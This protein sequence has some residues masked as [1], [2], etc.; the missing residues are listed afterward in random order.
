MKTI[1]LSLFFA[2]NALSVIRA[3]GED[4]VNHHHAAIYAH[5]FGCE[6][7]VREDLA[8]DNTSLQKL[9]ADVKALAGAIKAMI[10]EDP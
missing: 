3:D 10:A 2:L 7:T 5:L 6:E 1:T 8:D 4:P 9:Q